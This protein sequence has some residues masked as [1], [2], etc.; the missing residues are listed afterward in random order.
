M[1]TLKRYYRFFKLTGRSSMT[2]PELAAAVARHFRTID[3]SDK[4]VIPRFLLTVKYG[5]S[6]ERGSASPG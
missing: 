5:T 6:V 1:K 3:V 4:T 2:K